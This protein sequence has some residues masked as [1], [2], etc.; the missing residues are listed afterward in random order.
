MFHCLS[1]FQRFWDALSV[2][3]WLSVSVVLWWL[4]SV[5]GMVMCIR[6]LD[7]LCGGVERAVGCEMESAVC[8][9]VWRVCLH[10]INRSPL[11]RA[12][13]TPSVYVFVC[14]CVLVLACVCGVLN[15]MCHR[16]SLFKAVW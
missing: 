12:L 13:L 15:G 3:V 1:V 2:S 4:V 7:V 8:V 14:L 9:C 11:L 5:C 6:V 10:V 16:L